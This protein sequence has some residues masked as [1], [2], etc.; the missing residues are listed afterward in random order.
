MILAQWACMMTTLWISLTC[1]PKTGNSLK[2]LSLSDSSLNE[3]IQNVV[4]M[5][6]RTET[7]LRVHDIQAFPMESSVEH[8]RFEGTTEY[9]ETG[10]TNNN[11]TSIDS[12]I[13]LLF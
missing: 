1:D 5:V 3:N 7:S 11:Y 4:I 8:T 6:L 10:N 9:T 13:L 2:T 12:L